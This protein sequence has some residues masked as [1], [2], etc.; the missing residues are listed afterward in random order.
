MVSRW[1]YIFYIAQVFAAKYKLHSIAKV[2]AKAV[3]D[4]WKP[5]QVSNLKEKWLDK[6]NKEFGN[7][8]KQK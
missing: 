4:L 7:T 2:L 6:Q 1:N 8:L 3:K 5:I